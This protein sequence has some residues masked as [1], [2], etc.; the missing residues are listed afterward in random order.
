MD[1]DGR[2]M[3]RKELVFYLEISNADTGEMLG[4]IVDLTTRGCKVVN[5][6]GFAKGESYSLKFSLPDGRYGV[7]DITF[8]AISRWTKPDINPDY[9][10]TGFEII[11]L[12]A[13]ERKIVRKLMDHFGFKGEVV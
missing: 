9:L 6:D 2:I 4:H 13:N 8:N 12:G 3:T 11:R 10:V 5:K 1:S 7:P